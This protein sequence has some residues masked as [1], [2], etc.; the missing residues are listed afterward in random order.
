MSKKALVVDS[1][2]FFV[3]FVG[4][5]LE[6]RGYAVTKAYD[7]KDGISKLQDNPHDIMFVDLVMP[8]VDGSQFID[9]VRHK[10]GPNHFPIVALSG[11]MVEHL[12]AL[13][14]IGADYYMAKGPIDKLTVQ[15][16]E[17]MAEIETQSEFTPG[18]VKILQTEGVY[19]RRDAVELLQALKFHQA[20]IES[21]GVGVVVVDTDARIVNVNAIAFEIVDRSPIEVLNSPVLD[22]FPASAKPKLGDAL[23][24]VFKLPEKSKISFL[25]DFQERSI[26]T[27]VSALWLSEGKVGWVLVLED[28]TCKSL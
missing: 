8:K 7:G 10:Y 24:Q 12:G 18:E 4:E 9:F 20:V 28:T 3:E 21:M 25:A 16:N 11:V 23:K 5:L 17:F 26:R 27:T 15:L 13:K 22:I 14:D 6:K 1:D 2:Y 19:P